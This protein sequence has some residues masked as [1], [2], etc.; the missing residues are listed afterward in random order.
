M[1]SYTFT[2]SQTFSLTTHEVAFTKSKIQ[3]KL[4]SSGS[5]VYDKDFSSGIAFRCD[6]VDFQVGKLKADNYLSKSIDT[7]ISKSALWLVEKSTANTFIGTNDPSDESIYH[8]FNINQCPVLLSRDGD[9][10]VMKCPCDGAPC[11]NGCYKNGL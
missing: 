11:S 5:L 4:S 1:A 3:I 8:I 6:G 10:A 2:V 7:S 9:K